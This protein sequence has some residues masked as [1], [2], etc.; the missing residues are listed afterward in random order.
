MENTRIFIFR[1]R[2]HANVV[3]VQ[4]PSPFRFRF[5]DG[6]PSSL[7]VPLSEERMEDTVPSRVGEFTSLPSIDWVVNPEQ[8]LSVWVGG[9]RKS[10]CG[11]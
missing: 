10:A 3:L 11:E 9:E 5:R 6:L 4:F 7:L 1:H 2:T 8:A